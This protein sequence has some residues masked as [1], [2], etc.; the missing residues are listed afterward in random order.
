MGLPMPGI[1]FA[2][3]RAQVPITQVLDLIGYRPLVKT[4]T[5]WRGPCPIHGSTA[6]RSRVFSVNIQRNIY[7]CFKCHSAG[8]ALDLWVALT[9]QR[10]FQASLDLCKQLAIPIPEKRSPHFH[11]RTEMRNP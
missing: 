2:V 7:Q 4:K 10:L 11:R 3:L 6:P 1:D 8:N 9:R 5:Q